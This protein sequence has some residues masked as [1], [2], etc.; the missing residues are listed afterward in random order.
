MQL[1]DLPNMPVNCRNILDLLIV[2]SLIVQFFGIKII[3]FTVIF[4][5]RFVKTGLP[6]FYSLREAEFLHDDG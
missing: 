6:P 2:M 1:T 5:P 3:N 4:Y